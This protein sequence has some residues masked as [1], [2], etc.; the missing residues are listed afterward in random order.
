MSGRNAS[1]AQYDE[2]PP[3]CSVSCLTPPPPHEMPTTG[4]DV[5]PFLLLGVFLIALGT[6]LRS[7]LGP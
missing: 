4:Y 7:A 2:P 3:V 1:L 6:F 5:G